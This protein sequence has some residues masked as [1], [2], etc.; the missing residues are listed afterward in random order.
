[1]VTFYLNNTQRKMATT[2]NLELNPKPSKK[3]TY[4]ILLR[5][6]QDRKHKR[7]KTKVEVNKKG[8]FNPKAKPGFWIRTSEPSHKKWNEILESEIADAKQTYRDLRDKGMAS[9]ELIKSTMIEAEVSPSFIAFAKKRSEDIFNEGGYRNYKKY[10]GFCNKLETY[11]NTINKRDLMFSE[12]TTSFLS[13]FEAHLHTL[14][15]IRNPK[16]KLHPNTI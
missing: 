13:K 10:V 3:H 7:I 8:D 14:R 12:I 11:L 5:I 16:A 4:S 2:F 6:T 15:N 9:K 1:M